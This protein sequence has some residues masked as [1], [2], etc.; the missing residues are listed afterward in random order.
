MR[1][2][3]IGVIVTK[4]HMYTIRKTHDRGIKNSIRANMAFLLT[5]FTPESWV[6]VSFNHVRRNGRLNKFAQRRRSV[7]ELRMSNF[8]DIF[9]TCV[10]N[11]ASKKKEDE[12]ALK[13]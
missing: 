13:F 7:Y 1:T 9:R 8:L 2:R 6:G 3:M 5:S 10:D 12:E 4:F 11:I